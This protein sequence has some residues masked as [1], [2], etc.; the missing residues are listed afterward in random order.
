[1]EDTIKDLVDASHK[2][3]RL[4]RKEGPRLEK[5]TIALLAEVEIKINRSIS[6]LQHLHKEE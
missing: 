4:L 1:M 2:L 5:S 3:N 6:I